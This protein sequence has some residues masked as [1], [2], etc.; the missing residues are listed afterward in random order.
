MF[1]IKRNVVLVRCDGGAAGFVRLECLQG[2]T[3]GEVKMRCPEGSLLEMMADGRY[4]SAPANA[5]FNLP[6]AL[7]EDSR[8]AA[9][10]VKDGGVIALSSAAGKEFA[11]RASAG[12][13]KGEEERGQAGM[14]KKSAPA[15]E[16]AEEKKEKEQRAE[17][18]AP[19]KER[20]EQNKEQESGLFEKE[21]SK[22]PPQEEKEE[23]EQGKS[24]GREGKTQFLGAISASLEELFSLYPAEERLAGVVPFSKWV[25]VPLESGYY[26]V[27]VISDQEGA[28]R[29]LAYGVPDKDNASPPD[30]Y[31][32]CRG[33]LPLEEDGAG[34]WMMYQDAI[35]GEI[36]KK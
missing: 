11:A 28:A 2:K 32:A 24:E 14:E 16:S 25:R 6:F 22:Q 21:E 7:R 10:I 9:R 31:P 8:V 27:G 1:V 13:K 17:K 4:F 18:S 20:V 34:Y 15:K 35:T 33:W 36:V 23:E 26:V 29:Y 12:G 3:E 5:P 19:E 30:A